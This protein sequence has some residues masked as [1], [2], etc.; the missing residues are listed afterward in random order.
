MQ[1]EGVYTALVTPFTASGELDTAS[2]TKLVRHVV[3]GGGEGVVPLGTTGEGYAVDL[4][5]RAEALRVVRDAADASTGLIAGAT[6]SSTREAVANAQLAASLGY[7]AVM[8]APPPYA[9]PSPGELTSHFEA[10]AHQ[11]DVPV[12]LYDYP[13][14][15]GVSIDWQVLDALYDA[16]GIIA[17]K[18]ASGDFARVIEIRARYG[19]RYEIVCGADPLIVDFALWG[20]RSWIAGGS[21]FLPREHSA[22]LALAATGEYVAAKHAL[23]ELLPTLLSM[24]HDGYTHKVRAGL[25]AVGLPAG[26]PRGPLRRPDDDS[27][28]LF[29]RTLKLK[30]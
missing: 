7:H 9:L 1:F 10:I 12:V 5:E 18:E 17:I 29:L 16:T 2:L 8:V 13:A 25:E 30:V 28:S 6:S 4:E 21:A 14:R 3:E 27:I 22:I 11:A 15:T 23:E 26:Y 20:A 24:D 19:D